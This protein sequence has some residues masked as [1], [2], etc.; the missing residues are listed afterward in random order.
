MNTNH[1]YQDTVSSHKISYFIAALM[2]LSHLYYPIIHSGWQLMLK[3][4][5]GAPGPDLYQLW[6]SGQ[7]LNPTEPLAPHLTTEF[8][9][10][11]KPDYSN[12]WKDYCIDQVRNIFDSHSLPST[13]SRRAVVS[14]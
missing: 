14:L 3:G 8:F 11:Y 13:D 4:V 9:G 5:A 1:Q 12:H 6:H 2:I 10:H 7:T